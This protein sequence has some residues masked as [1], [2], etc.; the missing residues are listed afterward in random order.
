MGKKSIIFDL[1]ETL[2]SSVSWKPYDK[3][4]YNKIKVRPVGSQK[5]KKMWVVKRPGFDELLDFVGQHFDVGVWSAG[6]AAYVEEIVNTMFP[7]RPTFIYNHFH[8]HYDIKGRVY[9]PLK[10]C[11]YPDSI[12]I[13]DNINSLD[14]ENDDVARFILIEPFTYCNEKDTPSD[15][16]LYLLRNLLEEYLH[17]DDILQAYK[18]IHK[19]EEINIKNNKDVNF[20]GR[21]ISE[22]CGVSV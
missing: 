18:Y 3:I 1:D 20:A 12:I 14:Y 7:F 2:I 13:E 4:L 17:C 15:K 5:S 19:E 8:C 9:K 10:H 16:S 6:S 22:E 21:E 11:P